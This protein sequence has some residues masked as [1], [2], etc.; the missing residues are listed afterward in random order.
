M[1]VRR[2]TF[3]NCVIVLMA[4]ALGVSGLVL[5]QG[6]APAK[7]AATNKP[8]DPTYGELHLQTNIGSFKLID[9]VGRVEIS[10]TGSMLVSR[11]KGKVTPSAGIRKEYDSKDKQ[12]YHGSG[13]I[14]IDGEFRGIQWFGT[15]MKGIWRGR[16]VARITGEFDQNLETGYYWYAKDPSRRIPWSMYGMTIMN[17]EQMVG[18]TGVPVERKPGGGG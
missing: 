8:I 4:G 3:R 5:A 6:G 12:V 11:L 9:G 15:N 17:P 14:V 1:K 10:F 2:F 13:S 7:P 18:G 16:G